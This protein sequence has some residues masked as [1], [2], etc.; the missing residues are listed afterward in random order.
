MEF[1]AG[2]T[3]QDSLYNLTISS[4]IKTELSD[5]LRQLVDGGAADFVDAREL[6]EY[7]G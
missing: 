1:S 4:Y 6:V 7:Y 5:L 3:I 2:H